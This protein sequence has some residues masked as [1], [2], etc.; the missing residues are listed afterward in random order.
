MRRVVGGLVSCVLAL[1]SCGTTS[2][3]RSAVNPRG[4]DAVDHPTTTQPPK[5]PTSPT[6]GLPKA[7][8]TTYASWHLSAASSRQAVVAEGS[9]I[10]LLGG[11]TTGDVSTSAIYRVDPS[12]G[13][14][15]L[16]G[17]LARAVHDTAGGTFGG[18]ALVFGGGSSTTTAMVQAWSSGTAAEAAPLPRPRSDLASAAVSG[19]TFLVGGFDGTTL[20][21]AVLATSDGKSFVPAAKLAQPV[22]YPAVAAAGDAVWVIGGVTGT[23]EGSSA[24][25]D[26]IQR[27]DPRTGQAT[28]VGHLPMP[29]GHASAVDFGGQ[30]M[31]VGGRTGT[32]PTDQILRVDTATG[33]VT[34]IGKLPG[35]LSDAGS[36]V[37]GDTA[38]LLGGEV[39]GPAHPLDSVVEMHVT[40]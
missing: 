36:V 9:S 3:G 26:I 25:T 35:P 19:T 2:S 17:H 38:Y 5:A 21:P 40:P 8:Q 30:L 7:V 32:T 13:S 23:A 31:V 24:D 22:R 14:S 12:S 39:S 16:V 37:V 20:D 18:Q 34:S 11:L 28:V 4:N 33:A 15:D 10:V 27:I 1:G 29:L 6:S